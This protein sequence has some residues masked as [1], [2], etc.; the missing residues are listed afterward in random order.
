MTIIGESVQRIDDLD[1]VKGE[2]VFGA[3]HSSKYAICPVLRSPLSHARILEV[4]VKKA[5]KSLGLNLY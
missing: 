5:K 1:K 3:D 2:T 4:D